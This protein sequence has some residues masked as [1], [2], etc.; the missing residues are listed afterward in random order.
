ME[1]TVDLMWCLMPCG[2]IHGFFNE[3][4]VGKA[5]TLFR[6][7]LDLGIPPDVVTCNSII[8]GLCKVKAMDKA[9]EVL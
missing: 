6:E 2:V 9:E 4:K 3:G 1:M 7:M 8:D 5:Y